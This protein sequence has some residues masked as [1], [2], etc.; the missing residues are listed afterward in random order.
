MKLRW[1]IEVI[2][3]VLVSVTVSNVAWD[4]SCGWEPGMNSV[5][6]TTGEAKKAV[7]MNTVSVLA[8]CLL[9]V[10]LLALCGPGMKI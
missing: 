8:I 10:E 1:V 7:A 9:A 3:I 4:T 2:G 5:I 6:C